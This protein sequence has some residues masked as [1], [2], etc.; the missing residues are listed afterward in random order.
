MYFGA[1][2][3]NRSCTP[4]KNNESHTHNICN[5]LKDIVGQQD[6]ESFCQHSLNYF[7]QY[8]FIVVTPKDIFGKINES[9]IDDNITKCDKHG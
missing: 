6:C 2:T 9:P 3:N 7:P 4:N 5:E 1:P 8:Y